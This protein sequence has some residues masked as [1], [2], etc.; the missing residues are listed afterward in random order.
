VAADRTGLARAGAAIEVAGVA[1]RFRLYHE[2][3]PTSLKERVLRAGRTRHEDFWALRDIDLEVRR[4]E[5]MG[6]LGH[7]GSGK[8]TLLKCIAGILR[9]TS[10]RVV[11]RGRTA[12]LLEL[13]AGFHP[14][15][16]GRENVYLNGSILGLSR[17]EIDRRFDAIIE[18]AELEQ[19]VDNPVKHYSSGMVARLGFAVAVNVEPEILLV[20]EVL[21][22]GDE[23]FQRKC[24]G[25][26]RRLQSEGRTI[27][28]VTHAAEQVRNVCN[29]A[30]VLDRGELIALGTPG[31]AVIAFRDSLLRSGIVPAQVE[32]GEPQKRKTGAVQITGVAIEYEDPAAGHML[33]DEP[34]RV[35][36][37][38][39]AEQAVADPIVSFNVVDQRGTLIYGTNTA[40]L[41][42]ALG[43][44]A[45][46]GAVVFEF[47]RVALLEGIYALTIGV[48]DRDGVEIYDHRQEQDYLEVMNPGHESG[49]VALK[50]RVRREQPPAPPASGAPAADPATIRR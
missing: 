1:K 48:H 12:A 30:A 46:T 39:D 35:R 49:V 11:R 2:G 42:L 22:V 14:D 4:G 37:S 7:N 15:L 38:L 8:S 45:G 43:D 28:F 5:T 17:A 23:A 50:A 36:V 47:E 32:L 3:R 34:L 6:L 25:R 19:F 29:R 9:P 20:D 26:I 21:S 10:G 40:V 16:T 13:G 18:F 44:I 24:I 41:G 27:L 31:E 33:A